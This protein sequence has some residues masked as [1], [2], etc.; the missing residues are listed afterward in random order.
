MNEQQHKIMQKVEETII[1]RSMDCKR[2]IV[3]ERTINGIPIA[4]YA[5]VAPDCL[6]YCQPLIPERDIFLDFCLN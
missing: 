2:G 1:Q 3:G 6:L 5:R 4:G